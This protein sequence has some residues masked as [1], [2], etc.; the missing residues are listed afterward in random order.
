M[1][2]VTGLVVKQACARM[3]PGKTDVSEVYT[4]DVFLNAPDLLFDHLA[5]VFRSFLVHG[6][7][8]LHILSCVFLPLFKGGIKNPAV[9]DSSGQ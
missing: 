8:T 2:K 9:F 4:S 7:V 1:Q 5:A 3:K 6:T